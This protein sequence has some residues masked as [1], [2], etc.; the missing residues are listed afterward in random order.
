VGETRRA[1]EEAR[2]RAEAEARAEVL[3]AEVDDCGARSIVMRTRLRPHRGSEAPG[4]HP[5]PRSRGYSWIRRRGGP[6][7]RQIDLVV[8]FDEGQLAAMEGSACAPPARS[9][10]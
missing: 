10:R 7:L 5:S 4:G 6:V 2:G 9:P 3:A 1:E 8:D